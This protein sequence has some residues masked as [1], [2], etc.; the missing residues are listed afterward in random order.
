MNLQIRIAPLARASLLLAALCLPWAP[1][2]YAQSK[3]TPAQ[4]EAGRNAALKLSADAL[5]KLYKLHPDARKAIEGAAGYAVFDITSIYAILFVGQKGKGVL[6]DNKSKKTTFMTSTRM[7]TGPGAGKQR[8]FQVFVFKNKGAMD[9]FVLT[10]GLGGDVTATVSTGSDG[11]VRSFN[12]SIDIYQIPESGM[13]L[14][15]SWGGTVYA[16]DGDLN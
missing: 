14:Q 3:L 9:Q 2:A 5:D 1:N 8:V 13:A 7:G 10:G 15:A 4:K 6:F 12:P 11:S 16:V